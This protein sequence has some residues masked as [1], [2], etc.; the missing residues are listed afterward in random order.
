MV[1]VMN[2]TKDIINYVNYLQTEAGLF[3]SVKPTGFDNYINRNL[4][5]LDMHSNPY[6]LLVKSN[7]KC[8]SACVEEHNSIILK[9]EKQPFFSMCSAGVWE[10][11]YPVFCDDIKMCM[12]NVSGYCYDVKN[13]HRAIIEY[14]AKYERD[15]EAM[16]D[17]YDK[18]LEMRVPETEKITAV[19]NPLIYM[20]ELAYKDYPP[21]EQNDLYTRILHYLNGHHNEKIVIS[22]IAETLHYSPSAICHI[23]KKRNGMGINAYI[24]ELRMKEAKNLVENTK[25]SITEIAYAV[26]IS[27]SGYFSRL[28]KK[29]FGLPPASLRK[30]NSKRTSD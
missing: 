6:C 12:I 23:F 16:L 14:A 29:S 5:F 28:F 8:L 30:N 25:L 19:I 15:T 17:M 27:D 21:T 3:V 18:S 11:S 22:D 24:T 4:A 9:A 2:L 13:A 20:L 7:R 26:G 1:T 10:F